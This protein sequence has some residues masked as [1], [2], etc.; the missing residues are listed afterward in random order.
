MVEPLPTGAWT[1]G[2]L[3]GAIRYRIEGRAG[4]RR[5]THCHCSQCRRAHGAAFAT[6]G[7]VSRRRLQLERGADALRAYTSSE[8]VRRSFCGTCGSSLFWEHTAHP[9]FIDV[10]LGTLDDKM[11]Q[12]VRPVAHIF[13]DSRAPWFEISDGLPRFPAEMTR[14]EEP[15]V[16]RHSKP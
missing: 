14:A 8:L 13:V 5:V 2:C 7:V 4:P 12:S 1:G 10:A 6:Y 9:E 16:A 11:T 15:P 3:C